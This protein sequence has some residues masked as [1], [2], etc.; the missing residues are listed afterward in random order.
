MVSSSSQISHH[1]LLYVF[2]C[3][4]LPSFPH[5]SFISFKRNLLWLLSP[6]EYHMYKWLHIPI[7]YWYITLL[8]MTACQLKLN[9]RKTKLLF[10]LGDSSP[11]QDLVIS[12][13]NSMISP[14]PTAHLG[15][16]MDYQ[17]SFSSTL[18]I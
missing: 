16:T 8:W 14:L 17:L 1:D 12:L 15:V 5:F 10:V 9:P 18:L 11:V 2:L 6:K 3:S 13:E 7:C 4:F